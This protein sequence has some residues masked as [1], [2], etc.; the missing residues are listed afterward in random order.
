MFSILK[1][2]DLNNYSVLHRVSDF[3][4]YLEI[5]NM[6]LNYLSEQNSIKV[7]NVCYHDEMKSRQSSYAP[8][9][10]AGFM[11]IIYA[12]LLFCMSVLYKIIFCF[13]KFV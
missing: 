12:Y 8:I 2:P 6:L 11:I 4:V 13:F 1:Y 10:I 9:Y 3:I 5:S 7:V